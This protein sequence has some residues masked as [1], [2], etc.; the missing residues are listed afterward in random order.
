[1]KPGEKKESKKE[2]KKFNNIVINLQFTFIAQFVL[3]TW[4]RK[5][6]LKCEQLISKVER[7]KQQFFILFM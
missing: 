7:K 1:M 3:F 2:K 4:K 5:R 6:K